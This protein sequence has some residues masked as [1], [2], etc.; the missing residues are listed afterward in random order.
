MTVVLVYGGYT[1]YAADDPIINFRDSTDYYSV[2]NG[3]NG[4]MNDYFN[5]KIE[6]MVTL[7]ESDGFYQDA[8]KKAQFLPPANLLPGDDVAAIVTK[9]GDTNFSS[10][11]VGIGAIQTYKEYL[12]RLNFLK[13]N[14]DLTGGG[15]VVAT[16]ILRAKYREA[17]LINQES[18]DAKNV[19]EATVAAYNE[20]R[21]AYPMH[22][23]YQEILKQLT[24]YKLILKDIRLRIAE[25]PTR[26]I[27]ASTSNCQ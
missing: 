16:E 25:F 15:G 12:D 1:I 10:Y 27:D 13:N 4:E 26:F 7:V 22:K 9:C 18:T 20:F 2:F 8:K 5:A 21:L 3:Y 6:K 24:K 23:K 14:I 17:D 19:L 11:C